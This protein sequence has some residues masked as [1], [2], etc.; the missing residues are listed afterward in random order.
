MKSRKYEKERR[1]SGRVTCLAGKKGGMTSCEGEKKKAKKIVGGKNGKE[2]KRD[3][4][5]GS[6]VHQ[7]SGEE[8]E[9]ARE[10]RRSSLR[11]EERL[12]CSFIILLTYNKHSNGE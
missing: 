2:R 11:Y 9:L 3:N 12:T 8:R 6:Y 7:E 1:Q 4:Q 5:A 10:R